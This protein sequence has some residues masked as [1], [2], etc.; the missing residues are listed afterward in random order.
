[1]TEEANAKLT[2][3][4]I[5]I[6]TPMTGSFFVLMTTKTVLDKTMMMM[7]MRN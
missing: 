1:M 2:K 4:Y 5:I 7:M 3:R 6:D